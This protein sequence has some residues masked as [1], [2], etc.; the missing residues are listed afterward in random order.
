MSPE[1]IKLAR[2][3]VSRFIYKT[4]AM[5]NTNCLKLLLSMMVGIDNTDKT[6]SIAYCYITSESAVSFKWIVKQLTDLAF[7][8][9]PEAALIYRDFSKGL[10]TAVVAKA[11][12]D[13]AEIV[14][15]DEVSPQDA[16]AILEATE[17][18]VDKAAD[19]LTSVKLQL[20]E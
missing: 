13:L 6:F 17:V 3:F 16:S 9:C 18:I 14:P 10:R 11:I 1:Q 20:C 19:K 12:S 7:Y 5:F 4:D 2:W 15:T 8:N